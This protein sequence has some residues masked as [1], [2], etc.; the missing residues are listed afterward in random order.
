MSLVNSIIGFLMKKSKKDVD[1]NMI[2][3]MDTML[4]KCPFVAQDI[5]KELDNK[6]LIKCREVSVP[7]QNFID[8]EK[9]IWI[10]RMHKYNE[11]MKEFYEQWK[12][13]IKRTKTNLVKELSTVVVQFFENDMARR[14]MQYAPLH[15][16]AD[17]GL[18]ELSKI[19]IQ[20]TGDKNPARTDGHTALHMAALKGHTE[21]CKLIIE[22]VVNKN[23]ADKDGLTPLVIAANHGHLE[24]YKL[25]VKSF[26]D[27]NPFVVHVKQADLGD[28]PFHLAAGRG[29]IQVCEYIMNNLLD[30]NPQCVLG[31]SAGLTP[32]HNAAKFGHLKVC[33]LFL[34]KLDDKNPGTHLGITPLHLAAKSG[35]FD[36][37]E[38]IVD[39]IENKNPT[40]NNGKTPLHEAAKGGHLKIIELLLD[41]GGDR[42]ET[43]NGRTLIQIAAAYGHYR[44]CLS[45]IHTYP[46]YIAPFS[47]EIWI[48]G[49][50]LAQ[51]L[52]HQLF[53]LFG[54]AVMMMVISILLEYGTGIEV[55]EGLNDDIKDCIKDILYSSFK[56]LSSNAHLAEPKFHSFFKVI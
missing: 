3:C 45:L 8:N 35:Y 30:K 1:I 51:A 37:C 28:T 56:L 2:P 4:S 46:Q 27:K 34:E 17:K 26:E 13:V 49:T 22:I 41:N 9:F 18:L 5:F 7:W 19:I 29:H 33:Q 43:Y 40:A 53:L 32:Y 42:Y 50:N 6:S 23:P 16:A 20:R 12:L 15:V 10:R 47:M 38:K 52:L 44:L 39:S 54:V 11:S 36:I 48:Q 55:I 25:I 24:I 14:K 21:V 31:V